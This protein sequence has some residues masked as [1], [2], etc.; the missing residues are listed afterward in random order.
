LLV[1]DF[2]QWAE[3]QNAIVDQDRVTRFSQQLTQQPNT[4]RCGAF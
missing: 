4:G 1:D 3:R 2:Q